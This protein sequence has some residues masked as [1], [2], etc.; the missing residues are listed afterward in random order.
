[1]FFHRT[2]AVLCILLAV[3]W[4]LTPLAAAQEKP[5]ELVDRGIGMYLEGRYEKA[6]ELLYKALDYN[7]K[8][9]GRN[10]RLGALSYLAFCQI[11]LGDMA[12]A[13]ENFKTLLAMEPDYRLPAGTSPKLVKV[14]EDVRS[15]MPK[16]IDPRPPIEEKPPPGVIPPDKKPEEPQ[17]KKSSSTWWIWAVVG[18][19]LVGAGVT[20]AVLLS[21]EDEPTG[22]AIIDIQVIGP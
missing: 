1:M 22:N 13:R 12:G 6:M 14:F 10:R 19:V 15:K 4:G 21:G 2:C 8:D 7:E 3:L 17:P 20:L 9:L 16:K 18:G 11:A 5:G